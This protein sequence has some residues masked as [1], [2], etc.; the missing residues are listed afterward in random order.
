MNRTISLS[1]YMIEIKSLKEKILT[2]NALNDY[3]TI[4]KIE[5]N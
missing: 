4:K 1:K 5:L 2:K 3:F